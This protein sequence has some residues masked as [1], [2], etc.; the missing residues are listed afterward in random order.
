MNNL[1]Y[2]AEKMLPLVRVKPKFSGFDG[3]DISFYSI[4][5]RPLNSIRSD[6]FYAL[7]NNVGFR[8]YDTRASI[9]GGKSA[10]KY[11]KYGL[12]VADV[13]ASGSHEIERKIDIT[14]KNDAARALSA[15]ILDRNLEI[16]FTV[17]HDIDK[18]EN[19][20]PDFS[21]IRM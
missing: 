13:A 15:S 4:N 1:N 3:W 7:D 18:K 17:E 21:W 5:G 9:D 2:F 16:S 20:R 8:F 6:G 10:N 19:H 14:A 12:E 11:R